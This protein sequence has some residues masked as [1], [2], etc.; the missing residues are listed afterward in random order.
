MSNTAAEIAQRLGRDAEAVCRH[1]LSNGRKQGNYWIVGDVD[2]APGRSLYVRLT[3]P[4]SGKGSA[5]KW[6]DAAT[7]EHGDLLDLIAANLNL[8]SLGDTLDEARRFLSLP[9]S[10]PPSRAPV[11]RAPTGSPEAA[12]RLWAMGQSIA[13]T[14]VERYLA[15]RG[16]GSLQSVRA[17]RFHPSCYY[18][19]EGQPRCG[20]PETWPALLAKVTDEAGTLT[21]VHRTWLDPKTA[22]KAPLDPNRKAMGN[23]L[24]YAVR[25][26]QAREVMAVGEGLETMLSLRVAIPSLPVTAALSSAHLAAFDPPKHL[27]RL[28]IAVDADPAGREAAAILEKRILPMGIETI[29]LHPVQGDFNDDLCRLGLDNLRAQLRSQLA[30][31][32]VP[33]LLEAVTS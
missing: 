9:K 25:I 11:A 23:L 12:R 30:P 31:I 26:G 33:K 7:G 19:H 21:G 16:I 17:L 3:V 29:P 6:T 8:S 24:G 1:Y 10:D 28:Y 13:G 2:N 5:G 20:P 14:L 32:D 27:N 4:S 18:W 22:T 15:A